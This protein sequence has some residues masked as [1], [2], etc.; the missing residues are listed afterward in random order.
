MCF[1]ISGNGGFTKVA[2]EAD[3]EGQFDV[4]EPQAVGLYTQQI[5]PLGDSSRLA[6]SR[7]STL[8]GLYT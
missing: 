1:A 7:G 4:V 2:S 6:T 5:E 8:D 3:I